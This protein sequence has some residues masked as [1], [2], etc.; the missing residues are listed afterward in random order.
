MQAPTS[1]VSSGNSS[2]YQETELSSTGYRD[3]STTGR[4]GKVGWDHRQV[5]QNVDGTGIGA[6][7]GGTTGYDLE[8]DG[9]E[10]DS[11]ENEEEGGGGDDDN[12]GKKMKQR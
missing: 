6:S 3:I 11:E 8:G 1:T 4:S 5:I 12:Y 9:N 10:D 7:T 2:S